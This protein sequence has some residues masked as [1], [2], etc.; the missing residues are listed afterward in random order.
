MTIHRN[1]F[2]VSSD[3]LSRAFDL[4]KATVKK[5]STQQIFIPKEPKNAPQ[6]VD[7]FQKSVRGLPKARN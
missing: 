1:P 4:G 3:L 6:G 7:F 2:V 5:P